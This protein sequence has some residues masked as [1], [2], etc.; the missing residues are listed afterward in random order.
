M[1]GSKKRQLV[2]IARKRLAMDEDDYRA[3]L[4]RCAGVSSSKALDEDGFAF[5]MDEFARLGFR[6]A[7]RED[8]F[9]E[10]RGMCSPSQVR[11]I[12][13]LWS[14]YHGHRTPGKRSTAG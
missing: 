1:I 13:E 5:V 8:T 10:R 11:L 6:S 4:F 3:L 7:W 9:G 12:R 2:S 14:E